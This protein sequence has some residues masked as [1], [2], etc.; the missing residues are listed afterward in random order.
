MKYIIKM[1]F[2]LIVIMSV[3]CKDAT[4]TNNGN[5]EDVNKQL[6]M[7]QVGTKILILAFERIQQHRMEASVLPVD[8]SFIVSTT[9]I[10][11]NV[12]GY[13]TRDLSKNGNDKPWVDIYYY[14]Y[15]QNNGE[16]YN[17]YYSIRSPYLNGAVYAETDLNVTNINE[18]YEVVR[19]IASDKTTTDLAISGEIVMGDNMVSNIT[20]YATADSNLTDAQ[21]NINGGS[22]DITHNSIQSS[23]NILTGP[24]AP[25]VIVDGKVDSFTIGCA[26]SGDIIEFTYQM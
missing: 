1:F 19:L 26:V 13:Y 24:T 21:W 23:C 10:H 17:G 25:I 3:G 11:D 22:F 7:E 14:D 12:G 9:T 20:I 4:E 18:H 5:D 2:V 8:G 15:R 6:T 16:V